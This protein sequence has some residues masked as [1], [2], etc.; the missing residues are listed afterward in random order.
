MEFQD[1]TCPKSSEDMIQHTKNDVKSKRGLKEDILYSKL[2]INE[3]EK[4][5]YY[6]ENLN[7]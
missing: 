4:E 5:Y 2:Q 3:L 6:M 1:I 7:K